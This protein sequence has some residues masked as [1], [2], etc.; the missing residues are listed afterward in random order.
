M[1]IDP[2]T[3]P[4]LQ[5]LAHVLTEDNRDFVL[6][7]AA[8]PL[9]L[10]ELQQAGEFSGRETRDVDAVASVGSWEDFDRLRRRLFETGFR[11]G[12]IPHEF[13]F[14]EYVMVDLIPYGPGIVRD[15]RLEWR[16]TGRVMSTLG[17]EE[18]FASAVRVE[19]APGLSLPVVPVPAFILLKIIS[20]Q[21]RPEERARDL[22]DM[23][24]CF[25]HYEESIEESRRFDL[26]GV[27][28]KG[29]PVE[30]EEAGAYLLG[31]EVA[32]LARPSSLVAVHQFLEVVSDEF[33]RP[34]VQILREEGR[35]LDNEGRRRELFRLFRVFA[36]GLAEGTGRSSSPATR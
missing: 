4:A 33:T 20:Y 2:N 15:N 7:G 35:I 18:A 14:G 9:V 5:A 36:A 23:V 1:A 13:L 21:D 19:V 28:I 3:V 12:S 11:Q 17:I 31:L 27:E 6:I 25:E 26:A 30:F 24:Y 16:E 8:V 34:I 29:E 22:A 32:K 10:V